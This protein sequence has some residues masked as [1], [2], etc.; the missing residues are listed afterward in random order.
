MSLAQQNST[1]QVSSTCS[2][3]VD[4]LDCFAGV[5]LATD[6]MNARYLFGERSCLCEIS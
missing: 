2:D 1:A 5:A 3:I 6:V 4:L